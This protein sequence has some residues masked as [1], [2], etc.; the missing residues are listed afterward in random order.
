LMLEF[1]QMLSSKAETLG[2]TFPH[3]PWIDC[4]FAVCSFDCVAQGVARFI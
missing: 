2:S 4:G 3:P 1:N